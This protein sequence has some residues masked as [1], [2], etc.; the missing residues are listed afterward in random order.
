MIVSGWG[1]GGQGYRSNI[2]SIASAPCGGV[3]SKTSV[4]SWCE[5]AASL[6]VSF[7]SGRRER[8]SWGIYGVGSRY[9][10]RLVNA[11]QTEKT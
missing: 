1:G 11:Q 5:M 7:E 9:Q 3:I 10:I 2:D 8:G 4:V 6:E